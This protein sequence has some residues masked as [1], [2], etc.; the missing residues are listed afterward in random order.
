MHPVIVTG[1]R[2]Q[3]QADLTIQPPSKL[4]RHAHAAQNAPVMHQQRDALH[5]LPPELLAMIVD[6]VIPA[7]PYLARPYGETV[8]HFPIALAMRTLASWGA[9]CTAAHAL[10]AAVRKDPDRNAF[11]TLASSASFEL[12]GRTPLARGAAIEQYG[13]DPASIADPCSLKLQIGSTDN[14]ER[15]ANS[16]QKRA[17]GL[18]KLDLYMF[19]DGDPN[20]EMLTS[21]LRQCT[22]LKVLSL[23]WSTPVPFPMPL[24]AAIHAMPTLR[25]LQLH[26]PALPAELFAQMAEW[27]AVAE[28]EHLSIT[29]EDLSAQQLQAL[30]GNAGRLAGLRFLSLDCA[31][32]DADACAAIVDACRNLKRLESLEISALGGA[33]NVLALIQDL[34]GSTRV[35]RLG[36]H[37]FAVDQETGA[38]LFSALERFPTLHELRVS[39]PLQHAAV[40][41]VPRLLSDPALHLQ[42][43]DLAC[44]ELDE[45]GVVALAGAFGVCPWLHELRLVQVT[46]TEASAVAMAQVITASRGLLKLTLDECEFDTFG[47]GS[48]LCDAL[49]ASTALREF[50]IL[51]EPVRL[52]NKNTAQRLQMMFSYENIKDKAE[53]LEMMFS[54]CGEK[55]S[56]LLHMTVSYSFDGIVHGQLDYTTKLKL[57]QNRRR[58]DA[59]I[60]YRN[61]TRDRPDQPEEWI[62]VDAGHEEQ[63]GGT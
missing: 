2:K 59:G 10:M 36:L 24:L 49:E 56:S 32:L 48:L 27:P 11:R 7:S 17:S 34:A 35:T 39:G 22:G 33:V 46:F 63:A 45:A 6:R 23:G 58:L 52:D 38:A 15:Y 4:A 55:S 42:A 30:A 51:I 19:R 31:S 57:A 50:H 41:G 1:K 28:L 20:L 18:E 47:Q 40:R 8:G 12:L 29:T 3:D 44:D 43:L 13:I 21:A 14:L 61:E 53:M 62:P 9:S 37:R 54:H 60:T 5:D 16:L 25:S 26:G